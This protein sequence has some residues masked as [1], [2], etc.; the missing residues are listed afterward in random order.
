MCMVYRLGGYEI[1]M[2]ID[3]ETCGDRSYTSICPTDPGSL[4]S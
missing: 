1:N 4:L 3:Q 2:E